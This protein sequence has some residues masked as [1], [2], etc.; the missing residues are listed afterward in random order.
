MALCVD[1]AGAAVNSSIAT[2]S[3]KRLAAF[4]TPVL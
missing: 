4:L 2:H 1:A 3:D